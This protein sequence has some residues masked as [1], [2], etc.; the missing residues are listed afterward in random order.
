MTETVGSAFDIDALRQKYA[1]ERARR[2]RPDGIAQY[3]EIAG[4]FARFGDDPWVDGKFARE[5]LHDQVDVAIIGAG[6]GGLLTGARLR[7]LGVE[8]V[9]LIDRAADVGGTWYWNRYPG[10]ACDVESYVY[11]PLLEE[12]GYVP[13]EKY[14]KGPEIFAHCQRIAERYDLY[15]DACLQTDVREIRWD[16]ASS[17]WII[18]TDRGDEM[19][20]R[21][22]S[23]ANG[24]QAKPKLPGITGIGAFHGKAFHT[25]RWDYDYTGASLENLA[26][27][28]VGIIGT[29]ATAIQCVP[30]LAAAAQRLYVFQRTP[31]S[32]DVRANR[33]TDPQWASTLQPGWQRERIQNFQ[34]LTAGG[35]A[36]ED[37]VADAWTSI[38]RKLPVMRHDGDD[39][40]GAANPEQRTRD[41]EIADFAKMEEIRAR[42]DDIVVDRVTAEALK[43]WYGYFCK[44]PC[45]HDEYLQ[46]FNRDNVA[47][48]DTRGRGVERITESGVVVDGVSYDLDCLIFATGFEVGTDYCR[49]TGFELIGRDG[50]TLTQRW[51]DGVRTFQGLCANGFPNCFIESIA[52]AGLTVNFPYLL[53]VQATH[54]AWII[55]WALEHDAIEVE[56]SAGAEAAWVDTVVARSVASAERAK[57][58]T[59]G[60]YN[61][62]GKADA[63]TRQGS[64]FFGA[65]TEYADILEKWR[66]AG[67]LDGFEIRGRQDA[68]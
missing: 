47:L 34:I 46:A 3:V 26:D 21:F 23:M 8:S 41:I 40:Q 10:I 59:P 62:E 50:V 43:P 38:T 67:D 4:E 61:R 11:M 57:T 60:Y 5:P 25:S 20:A 48:V 22:V 45:F 63:K 30:H 39:L 52:Q 15:R 12:L 56:A 7:Q 35:Q 6:F 55:A 68:P 16:A 18:R 58:C 28:R 33:P 32:V 42:V 44:R 27:K 49:R 2:L 14:A 53:D 13:T 9:R 1:A 36:P 24:Y 17:R 31:S 66:A 29:G 19:R 51:D 37:L 65:P 64:F 54:V